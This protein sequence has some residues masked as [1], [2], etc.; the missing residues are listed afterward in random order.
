M[1]T[2]PTPAD[3]AE[4]AARQ[5]RLDALYLADGRDNPEHKMHSLYTG[6]CIDN[7]PTS[8]EQLNE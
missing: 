2:P 7:Q 8:E 6:L 4:Q 1:T 5:K 3:H